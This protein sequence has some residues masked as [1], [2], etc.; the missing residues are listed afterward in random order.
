MD[1]SANP[2][3]NAVAQIEVYENEI[4]TIAAD[5]VLINL[6][7]ALQAYMQGYIRMFVCYV[8]P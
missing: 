3:E 4:N 6:W 5:L 1:V 2:Q 7:I 8:D